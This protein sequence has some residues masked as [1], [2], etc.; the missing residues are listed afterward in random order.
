MPLLGSAGLESQQRHSINALQNLGKDSA[1]AICH[2]PYTSLDKVCWSSNPK[3]KHLFHEE[4]IVAWLVSCGWIKTKGPD[5]AVPFSLEDMTKGD[6]KLLSYDLE[7]PCCR[8]DF[9]DKLLLVA[10]DER[11]VVV[12]GEENV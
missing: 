9:V 7:C 8:Q 10:H 2:E 4:C 6:A 5:S 3:C 12:A 11:K 1:C